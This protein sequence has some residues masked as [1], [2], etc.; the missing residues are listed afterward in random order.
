[1]KSKPKARAGLLKSELADETLVYDFETHGAHCM[2]TLAADV[3]R[4]CDGESSTREIA[5]AMSLSVT[6]IER[7]VDALTSARL[8]EPAPAPIVNRARRRV[9]GQLARTA[10]LGVAAPLVW[11]IVAPSVAEAASRVA[12]V[13]IG[14]CMGAGSVC[15]G[16]SG[17]SAMACSGGGTCTGASLACTGQTCR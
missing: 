16:A 7:A 1:M 9:L 4:R 10:A 11:S 5:A 13:P 6:E 3:L 15:C 12:C 2:T 8:L 17:G 14:A